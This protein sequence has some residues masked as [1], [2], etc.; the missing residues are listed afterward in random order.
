MFPVKPAETDGVILH[1][2]P[3]SFGG[4]LGTTVVELLEDR[5]IVVFG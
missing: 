4:A 3:L 5:F 2:E 1:G